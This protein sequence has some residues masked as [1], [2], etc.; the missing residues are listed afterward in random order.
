MTAYQ[1]PALSEYVQLWL[2]FRDA[3][4]R[5]EIIKH[6]DDCPVCIAL[7]EATLERR[8][9][10]ERAD[11]L[12]REVSEQPL[13][14]PTADGA[15]ML[16]N[17]SRFALPREGED[18]RVCDGAIEADGRANWSLRVDSSIRSMVGEPAEEMME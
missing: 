13:D 1:C 5:A 3:A 12:A 10:R 17:V 14:A 6:R 7:Q 4:L 18:R 15:G 9:A 11:S 8:I 16:Q 2:S